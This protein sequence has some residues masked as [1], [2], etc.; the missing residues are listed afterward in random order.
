MS[1]TLLSV[2]STLATL[3]SIAM[4]SAQIPEMRLCTRQRSMQKRPFLP[5]LTLVL[6]CSVWLL[7]GWLSHT[8]AILVT[9]GYG[10]VCALYYCSVFLTYDDDA[11]RAKQRQQLGAV[12]AFVLFVAVYAARDHVTATP[13]VGLLASSFAIAVFAS[14]LAQIVHVVKT[15]SV[16]LLSFPFAVASVVSSGL[17][18]AFGVLAGDGNV[19][20]PNSI[21]FLLSCAQLSLFALYGRSAPKTLEV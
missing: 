20:V 19:Y 21:A 18:T 7:Y 6:N 17:W 14:P 1:A 15:K 8:L 16:A 10:F 13:I 3:M 12:A 11:E 4:F 5:F 9:N 2:V